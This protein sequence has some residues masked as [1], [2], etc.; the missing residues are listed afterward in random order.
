MVSLLHHQDI[1]YSL[2]VL[3]VTFWSRWFGEAHGQS[4]RA[5][6]YASANDD[7]N[8]WPFSHFPKLIFLGRKSMLGLSLS[9][10]DVRSSSSSS[11]K[12]SRQCNDKKVTP[13]GSGH[14]KSQHW[15]SNL[16]VSPLRLQAAELVLNH[17]VELGIR[18]AMRK[19][20]LA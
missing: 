12:S 9:L 18:S 8:W 13:G 7:A 6:T 14:S 16:Q 1:A 2:A 4:W 5:A 15:L 20:Q 10:T 19:D 17:R 3:P 11:S